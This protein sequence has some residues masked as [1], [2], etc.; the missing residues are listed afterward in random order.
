MVNLQ[1]ERAHFYKKARKNVPIN[2]I[3]QE[4]LQTSNSIETI[5]YKGIVGIK[6]Q[7]VDEAMAHFSKDFNV[8]Y[9][10][11][12]HY[13]DYEVELITDPHTPFYHKLRNLEHKKFKQN[14]EKKRKSW[15]K[16]KEWKKKYEKILRKIWSFILIPENFQGKKGYV[17]AYNGDESY[18]REQEAKTETYF[19]YKNR[20]QDI[21]AS[22]PYSDRLYEIYEELCNYPESF[23]NIVENLF[24]EILNNNDTI[25]WIRILNNFYNSENF[26]NDQTLFYSH[27][28]KI[29][30]WGQDGSFKALR[31]RGNNKN[32]WNEKDYNFGIHPSEMKLLAEI[33]NQIGHF[34]NVYRPGAGF[35]EEEYKGSYRITNWCWAVAEHTHN[36][37]NNDSSNEEDYLIEEYEKDDEYDYPHVTSLTLVGIKLKKIPKEIFSL[38]YLKELDLSNNKITSIPGEFK[39]LRFLKSLSL[40]DNPIKLKYLDLLEVLDYCY[41]DIAKFIKSYAENEYFTLEEI[42]LCIKN[43]KSLDFSMHIPPIFIQN[44]EKILEICQQNPTDTAKYLEL[45]A[46]MEYIQGEPIHADEAPWLRNLLQELPQEIPIYRYIIDEIGEELFYDL[47]LGIILRDYHVDKLILEGL[48]LKQLPKSIFHFTKMRKLFLAKNELTELSSEMVKLQNLEMI[49]ISRNNFTDYPAV[50]GGLNNLSNEFY[51]TFDDIES[52]LIFWSG[53]DLKEYLQLKF[54][55]MNWKFEE[56]LQNIKKNKKVRKVDALFPDLLEY[57]EQILNLINDLKKNPE[58]SELIQQIEFIL[59]QKI[60]LHEI[61]HDLGFSLNFSI[62]CETKKTYCLKEFR[63][64]SLNLEDCNLTTLPDGIFDLKYLEYLKISD[65]PIKQISY[66]ILKLEKLKE[67]DLHSTKIQSLP[68]NIIRFN[69]KCYIYLND[70]L[71]LTPLEEEILNKH[72]QKDFDEYLFHKYEEWS[73]QDFITRMKKN[74]PATIIDKT[75]PKLM[76]MHSMLEDELLKLKT[77]AATNFLDYL[78]EISKI[79]LNNSK[80]SIF[81]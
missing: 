22:A 33:S 69:L 20:E 29:E 37:F 71:S 4:L 47:Q 74:E 77:T 23:I 76:K 38:K 51:E 46:K 36:L 1:K 9:S 67:F 30:N 8:F 63:I 57:K 44:K 68:L 66:K 59:H 39:K 3:L 12:C 52:D 32:S 2:Q 10:E 18:W 72:L 17:F 31:Q 11:F 5:L 64:I 24:S 15:L 21:F 45:F 50:I 78:R 54:Q 70:D 61:E 65:N 7:S 75:H 26:P 6:A 42:E 35:Y 40:F 55:I 27:K 62:D 43:N 28:H 53:E 73:I 48:H 58:N 81:L 56:F 13:F 60:T 80:Y 19:L 14:Y 34:I 79:N 41:E 49:D 16:N 25:T